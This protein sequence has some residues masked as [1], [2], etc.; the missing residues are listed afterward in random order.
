[1][2]KILIHFKLSKG[3]LA[4]ILL[5]PFL[6]TF[7]QIILHCFLFVRSYY[8]W[9]TFRENQ[10]T[11]FWQNLVSPEVNNCLILLKFVRLFL[12]KCIF[13]NTDNK[14]QNGKKNF[15]VKL[16]FHQKTI[17]LDFEQFSKIIIILNLFLNFLIIENVTTL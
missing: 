3:C 10:S 14:K 15:T 2:L 5:G 16:K 6:T 1:M 12:C 11:G 13:Y 8:L 4:H 17:K 7:T 9:K